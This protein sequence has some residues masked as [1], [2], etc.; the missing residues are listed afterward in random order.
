M[1]YITATEASLK[2]KE[3]TYINSAS[4]PTGELK[5]GFLALVDNNT[6]V[7]ALAT[8]SE[9]IDKTLN[10]VAEAYSRGGK[11]V[12]ISQFDISKKTKE[13]NF[14]KLNEIS[15]ELMP[16]YSVTFFQALAYYTSIKKG[17]NPDKP[18]NLAKSVTVE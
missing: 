5:H 6:Y 12:I 7:V 11:I 10:G 13:Y 1:D 2:L 3:I 4:H 14:I 9:L 16:I 15:E 18:R 8:Q 17:I